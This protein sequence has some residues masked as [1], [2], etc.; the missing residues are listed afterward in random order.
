MKGDNVN[1]WTR[2][3]VIVLVAVTSVTY[4]QRKQPAAVVPLRLA[5]HKQEAQ[6]VATEH[7]WI[8]H[9]GIWSD[10]ASW[11]SAQIPGAGGVGTDSAIFNGQS[12]V[13]VIG[14]TPGGNSLAR[15]VTRREYLGD[16][17]APGNPLVL[18]IATSATSGEKLTLR[19]RGN[20]YY[21]QV[22]G[23]GID[24]VVDTGSLDNLVQFDGG[25]FRYVFVKSG[26]VDFASTVSEITSLQVLNN[27]CKVTV[28]G[29]TAIVNDMLILA[30]T[31]VNNHDNWSKI[32][33]R[34]GHL[35]QKGLLKD[36]V[37]VLQLG[38]WIEYATTKDISTHNPDLFIYGGTFDARKLNANLTANDF[39]QGPNATILGNVL[40]Q[41][42]PS[43]LGIVIDLSETYP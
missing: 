32:N 13:S 14:E 23:D 33:M 36:T 43:G 41:G 37:D 42:G 8:S 7:V 16:I 5:E 18:E 34:G 30:G 25:S 20:V 31:V 27:L 15:L 40:G 21:T 39:I 22:A 3:V 17:A 10:A 2:L 4:G 19:G 1:A 28:L 12:N 24:V 11:D 35:I 38:G 26:K 9:T 29:S 6:A